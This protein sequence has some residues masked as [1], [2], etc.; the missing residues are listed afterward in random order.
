M[1][2]VVAITEKEMVLCFEDE[3]SEG[4]Q[5]I[6]GPQDLEKYP[7]EYLDEARASLLKSKTSPSNSVGGA[8][9]LLWEVLKWFATDK[10]IVLTP[11]SKSRILTV[12]GR[13]HIEHCKRNLDLEYQ[14]T[15][16]PGKDRVKDQKKSKFGVQMTAIVDLL[17]E[18]GKTRFT[19]REILEILDKNKERIKAQRST[20]HVFR[21][22][23]DRLRMKGFLLYTDTNVTLDGSPPPPEGTA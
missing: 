4:A 10:N 13:P 14:L 9:S 20:D 17:L 11:Q 8:A 2:R 7:M 16:F 3:V 22:L 6:A 19:E 1:R 5:I 23:R 21:W 12:F 18:S 15:Y